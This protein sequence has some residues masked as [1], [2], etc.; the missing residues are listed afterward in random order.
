MFRA[1]FAHV[2]RMFRGSSSWPRRVASSSYSFLLL[3]SHQTAG[4]N[5]ELTAV[6][7]VPQ[8]AS[9]SYGRTAEQRSSLPTPPMKPHSSASPSM[10]AQMPA[11]THAQGDAAT[12]TE[13]SRR[14][15]R[16]AALRRRDWRRGRRASWICRHWMP[17]PPL[18]A[19][20]CGLVR[21]RRGGC[22]RPDSDRSWAGRLRA[23]AAMCDLLAFIAGVSTG[24]KAQDQKPSAL[25][26]RM[27]LLRSMM[28]L[29]T[30]TRLSAPQDRVTRGKT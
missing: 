13:L 28:G 11:C 29:R 18:D 12:K 20:R 1:C 27:E 16:E 8:T 19:P 2:S 17:L 25:K 21:S 6:L 24:I 30:R 15:H 9:A 23:S 3:H 14:R 26:A 4:R 5:P 10:R 22:C 7:R